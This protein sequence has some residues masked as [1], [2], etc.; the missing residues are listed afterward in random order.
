MIVDVPYEF[1][2]DYT[3]PNG[4][5]WKRG[6]FRAT[7]PVEVG[8]VSAS[9]TR[10]L[11]LVH[12]DERLSWLVH[13][14]RLYESV[15]GDWSRYAA[16]P[17]DWAKGQFLLTEKSPVL[18]H[19]IDW[20]PSSIV[21]TKHIESVPMRQTRYVNREERA[22]EA[23]ERASRLLLVEGKLFKATPGPFHRVA[24]MKGGGAEIETVKPTMLESNTAFK[25]FHVND[26]EL[27]REMTA[28]LGLKVTDYGVDLA[29]RLQGIQ[30]LYDEG[31]MSRHAM[32]GVKD[33]LGETLT[34][35]VP[36]DYLEAM[37]TYLETR[38]PT[39][40]DDLDLMD[41]AVSAADHVPGLVSATRNAFVLT[42]ARVARQLAIQKELSLEPTLS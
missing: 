20:C 10:R 38:N 11:R 36:P 17:V 8:E 2:I 31:V 41:A 15:T 21:K 34:R 14:G 29:A 40:Q 5:V 28:T 18:P 39:L 27:A 25:L 4:R 26:L 9:E 33:F 12:D 7:V 24:M 3:V 23:A 35:N 37:A 13:D 22:G 1:E 32:G 16:V 6:T 19:K 30:T 42:R